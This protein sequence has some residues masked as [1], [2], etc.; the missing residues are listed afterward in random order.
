MPVGSCTMLKTKGRSK[1][2]STGGLRR[3]QGER[4]RQVWSVRAVD[5]WCAAGRRSKPGWQASRGEEHALGLNG[6]G[7]A[8]GDHGHRGGFRPLL[9]HLRPRA[10]AGSRAGSFSKG[11]RCIG[12]GGRLANRHYSHRRRLCPL[13]IHLGR[14]GRGTLTAMDRVRQLAAS[15][16]LGQLTAYTRRPRQRRVA[17]ASRTHLFVRLVQNLRHCQVQCGSAVLG[18]H[19]QQGRKVA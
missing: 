11:S 17:S 12:Q 6:N 7:H 9:I 10:K 8:H 13:L 3:R 14:A 15:S 16:A 2:R 5:S 18:G 4:K 19:L 1:R